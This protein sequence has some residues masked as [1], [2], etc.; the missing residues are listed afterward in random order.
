MVQFKDAQAIQEKKAVDEALVQFRSQCVQVKAK[1]T[2]LIALRA[3]WAAD[4]ATY[5]AAD[6]AVLD[7]VLAPWTTAPATP[8]TLAEAIEAFLATGLGA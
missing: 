7:A 6:L 5:T 1:M 4:P 8:H 2:D 3:K